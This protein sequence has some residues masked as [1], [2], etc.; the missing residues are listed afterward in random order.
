KVDSTWTKAN[1]LS[2]AWLPRVR[3]RHP[4]PVVGFT[5]RPPRQVPCA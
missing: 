5:A 4:C 3:V 1:N 2:A